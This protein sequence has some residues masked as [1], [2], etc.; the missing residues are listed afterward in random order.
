MGEVVEI[1]SFSAIKVDWHVFY[2]ISLFR[3]IRQKLPIC[4]YKVKKNI[5]Q[6]NLREHLGAFF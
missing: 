4:I 1:G 3:D 5:L 6:R 2:D